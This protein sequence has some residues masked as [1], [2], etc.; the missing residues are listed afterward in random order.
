MIASYTIPFSGTWF[1][2]G[3]RK[4]ILPS[5]TGTLPYGEESFPVTWF[6]SVSFAPIQFAGSTPVFPSCADV[7]TIFLHYTYGIVEILAVC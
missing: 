6:L 1:K 3:W 4:D 5:E 2:I 7:K